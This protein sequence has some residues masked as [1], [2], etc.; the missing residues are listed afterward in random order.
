MEIVQ[1]VEK[2]SQISSEEGKNVAV[3]KLAH[4]LDEEEAHLLEELGV[5]AAQRAETEQ[6][7][8]FWP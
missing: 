1:T 6:V 8:L 7:K 4:E 2:V 5:N 3:T